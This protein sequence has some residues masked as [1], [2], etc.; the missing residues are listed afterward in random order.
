MPVTTIDIPNDLLSFIDALIKSG[1]A[2][3]RREIVVRSLEIFVKLQA[4]DWN[5]SLIVIHGV[6]KGL[7][8]KGSIAELV[9]GMS[10]EELYSAGKR[11]GKT[12]K[13][14]AI[15]RHLDISQPENHKVA[16]QMLEDFGWARFLMDQGRITITG[17]FLPAA[18]IHGYLETALGITLSR[19]DTTEDIIVFEMNP[20]AA[21]ATRER[22]TVR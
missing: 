22:R 2:R 16:L 13:D 12:L 11:M 20:V 21:V 18:V 8:S 1:K 3:N 6:R 4:Q 5:G 17:A 15:D 14:L 7:I 10:E 19:I 9:S